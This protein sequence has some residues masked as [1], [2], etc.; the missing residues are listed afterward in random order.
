VVIGYLEQCVEKTP[1]VFVVHEMMA[2]DAG[3]LLPVGAPLAARP[4]VG[5]D[6]IDG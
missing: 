5:A 6:L 4:Q 1:A 2:E 3:R